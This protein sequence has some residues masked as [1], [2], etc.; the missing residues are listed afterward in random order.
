MRLIYL[1]LEKLTHYYIV[2][3]PNNQYSSLHFQNGITLDSHIFTNNIS[4]FFEASQISRKLLLF[5]LNQSENAGRLSRLFSCN[6]KTP[7]DSP[8][9][10]EATLIFRKILLF[11]LN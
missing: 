7:E 4:A 6:P 8:V 9:H 3:I 1:S 2:I 11:I 10:F 5:V